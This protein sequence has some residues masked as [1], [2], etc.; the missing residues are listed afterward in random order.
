MPPTMPIIYRNEQVQGHECTCNGQAS[1]RSAAWRAT[2]PAARTAA[3]RGGGRLSANLKAWWG[4]REM[5]QREFTA[6]PKT[7]H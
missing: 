1:D 4:E 2:F 3:R 6:K 7:V 5:Q